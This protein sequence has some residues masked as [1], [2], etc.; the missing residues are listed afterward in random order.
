MTFLRTFLSLKP[1]ETKNPRAGAHRFHG[2]GFD[3]KHRLSPPQ[4]GD[5][6]PGGV[7]TPPKVDDDLLGGVETPPQVDDD[8]PA[9][10]NELKIEKAALQIQ[11][12]RLRRWFYFQAPPPPA[13]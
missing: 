9:R 10:K 2:G 5:D 12:N 13:G 6:L 7:E 11:N 3:K 4:V 1:V 8:L